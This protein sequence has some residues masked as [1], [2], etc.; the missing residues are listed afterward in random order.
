MAETFRLRIYIINCPVKWWFALPQQD[1]FLPKRAT[2]AWCRF[3]CPWSAGHHFFWMGWNSFWIF[4]MIVVTLFAKILWLVN[5]HQRKK[6]GE[7]FSMQKWRVTYFGK[8]HPSKNFHAKK[9]NIKPKDIPNKYSR[10]IRC[11]NGAPK[12]FS[13]PRFPSMTSLW[14]PSRQG[15]KLPG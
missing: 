8:N 2:C 12:I 7:H 4:S 10:D 6:H 15:K 5:Q 3:G 14:H 1:L 13:G 9:N 11:I